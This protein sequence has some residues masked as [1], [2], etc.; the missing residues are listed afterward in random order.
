[1]AQEKTSKVRWAD[2][3]TEER[4]QSSPFNLCQ[5]FGTLCN[6]A[7]SLF[8]QNCS[9]SVDTFPFN[10]KV[11]QDQEVQLATW[12]RLQSH[13]NF[14]YRAIIWGEEHISIGTWANSAWL[15]LVLLPQP[16]PGTLQ[17]TEDL[18][19]ER[20]GACEICT[21]F[22]GCKH[23]RKAGESCCIQR[24]LPSYSCLKF[25]SKSYLYFQRN[26]FWFF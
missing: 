17:K 19:L 23:P 7:G 1:M 8:R 13:A 9:I 2:K 3:R 22:L 21:S 25:L 5:T 18:P 14:T 16:Y 6:R 10:V 26:W 4:E 11:T 15:Q 12:H 20:T 24:L